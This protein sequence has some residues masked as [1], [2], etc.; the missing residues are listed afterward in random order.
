[1]R[2]I[3]LYVVIIVSLTTIPALPTPKKHPISKEVNKIV[4]NPV[5]TDQPRAELAFIALL[6]KS[7]VIAKDKRYSLLPLIKKK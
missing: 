4:P 7:C 2:K 1:M 3:W 5:D 6:T